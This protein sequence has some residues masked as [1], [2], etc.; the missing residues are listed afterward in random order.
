MTLTD[1]QH[2]SKVI[3][4]ILP[5]A[6]I[7]GGAVRDAFLGAAIKDIDVFVQGGDTVFTVLAEKLAHGL[8]GTIESS[9][10]YVHAPSYDIQ[11]PDFPQPVNL[12]LRDIDVIEDI[13]DYDFGISQIAYAN[14]VL[15]KTPAFIEDITQSSLTYIHAPVEKP[16]WHVKSSANRM[17]RILAKHPSL[18]PVNCEKLD[19]VLAPTF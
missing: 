17:A 11:C 1:L 4:Q 8:S 14:G 15:I 12:V 3:H 10:A 6:I 7:G 2:L 13:S 9:Q 18:H 19:A 16:E 5:G